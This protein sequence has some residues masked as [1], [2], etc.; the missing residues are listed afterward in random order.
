MDCDVFEIQFG[1]ITGNLM[2]KEFQHHFKRILR[3]K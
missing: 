2:E 1:G 3:K